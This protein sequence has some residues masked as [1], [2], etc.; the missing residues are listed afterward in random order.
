ML[1]TELKIDCEVIAERGFKKTKK[2]NKRW[3]GGGKMVVL[4]RQSYG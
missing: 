3:L 2:V 1:K 4:C